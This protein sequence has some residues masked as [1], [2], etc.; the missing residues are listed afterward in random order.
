MAERYT[1]AIVDGG[2]DVFWSRESEVSI[3]S[4]GAIFNDF[5]ISSLTPWYRILFNS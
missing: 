1:M 3:K 4:E 5:N 2:P